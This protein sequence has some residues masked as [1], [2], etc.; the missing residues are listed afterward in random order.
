MYPGVCT[1]RQNS[2]GRP[3][4]LHRHYMN[5][6]ADII[7]KWPCDY[8][9]CPRSKETF[10]RKDHYRDHLKAYH[11]EDIGGFKK[12][13]SI[14]DR[15]FAQQQAAWLA[16]RKIEARY[17]RCVH[18]L[19]KNFVEDVGWQCSSCKELSEEERIEA[20]QGSAS[21][22]AGGKYVSGTNSSRSVYPACATCSGAG[23]FEDSYGAYRACAGCQVDEPDYYGDLTRLFGHIRF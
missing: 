8:P 16:E 18:S 12:R 1:G 14:T 10:T 23:W 9:T 2:F 20:R 13:A 3:S 17:W 21:K 15:N 19:I 7:D 11:E 6:H 4:D 22:D 5:V